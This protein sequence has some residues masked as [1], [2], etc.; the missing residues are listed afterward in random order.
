M[1]P[2]TFKD[3]I[4]DLFKDDGHVV[5]SFIKSHKRAREEATARREDNYR[6]QE[7]EVRKRLEAEMKAGADD[8]GDNENAS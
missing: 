7:E 8:E 1:K 5:E 3:R 4:E 6:R 2:P